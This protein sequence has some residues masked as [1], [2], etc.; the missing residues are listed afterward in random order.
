M[1]FRS[2]G[3]AGTLV[4]G[5]IVVDMKTI[6][7]TDNGYTKDNP[8]EKLLAHLMSNDFFNVND[9]A[10]S[11]FKITGFENNEV[12]GDLTVRDK[13]NSEVAK[14][15]NITPTD[16]GFKAS[17]KLVF[18]RQNYGVAFKMPVKD[19]VLSDDITLN[20]SLAATK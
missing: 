1:G 16:S 3:S 15:V 12:K 13:T 4:G 18:N 7:P 10:T 17:G 14:E 2:I 11:T 6:M 5:N 20:I 9:F 8:K 19:K